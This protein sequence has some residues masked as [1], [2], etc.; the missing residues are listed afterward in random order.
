MV[1][2]KKSSKK[3]DETNPTVK[4]LDAIISILLENQKN[5]N[6]SIGQQVLM[7]TSAKF[8]QTEIA[9]I[10]GVKSS[11]IPSYLR[12]ERTKKNKTKPGEVNAKES[13]KD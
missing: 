1:K 12:Y 3:I 13:Q 4:R 6:V 8:S 11:S 5:D 9:G 7:L 10:L 2:P